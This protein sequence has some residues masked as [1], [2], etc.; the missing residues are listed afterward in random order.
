MIDQS[1]TAQ[2]AGVTVRDRTGDK[3]GKVSQ[4]YLDDTTGQPAWVTVRTGLFGARESFVPLA[5]A[6]AQGDE[7]VV[8]TDKDTVS[9]APQVDA[10][11]DLSD[12]QEAELYRYYGTTAFSAGAEAVSGATTT[13]RTAGWAGTPPARPRTRR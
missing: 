9:S 7:L 8:D 5:A 11:G 12:E 13:S 4:I 10:D 1:T 2:L 6:V 3:L